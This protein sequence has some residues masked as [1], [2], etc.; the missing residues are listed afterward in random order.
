M[1]ALLLGV[2]AT[3]LADSFGMPSSVLYLLASVAVMFAVY[4]FSCY[5]FVVSDQSFYLRII[6]IANLVYCL[7]T[8]GIVVY[9]YPQLTGVGLIYFGLEIMIII[10]LVMMELKACS[11]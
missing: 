5:F 2:V 8:V 11:K 1:S 7:L 6:A 4:S 9:F 10:G 3:S